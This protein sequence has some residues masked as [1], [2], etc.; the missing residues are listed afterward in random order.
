[1][2]IWMKTIPF[3]ATVAEGYTRD[4]LQLIV[5]TKTAIR[6]F[7]QNIVIHLQH[8]IDYLR[9]IKQESPLKK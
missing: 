9:S 2:S 6:D 8:L 7:A 1:M 3:T 5:A 4:D